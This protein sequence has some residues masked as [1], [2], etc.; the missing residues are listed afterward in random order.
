MS[1]DSD[2]R[3]AKL[4]RVGDRSS[5]LVARGSKEMLQ[6]TGR[7]TRPLPL[8]DVPNAAATMYRCWNRRLPME[9]FATC[10][11]TNG[12]NNVWTW[13][14]AIHHPC[15]TSHEPRATICISRRSDRKDSDSER[16]TGDARRDRRA[17]RVR[18]RPPQRALADRK[19]RPAHGGAVRQG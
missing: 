13:Q 18:L 7:K 1:T 16:R 19:G 5:W 14:S 6:T 17:Q 12:A 8:P 4:S 3:Q 10:V 11:H 2:R 15:L 9:C